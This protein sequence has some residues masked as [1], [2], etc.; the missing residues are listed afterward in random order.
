MTLNTTTYNYVAYNVTDMPSA[1]LRRAA[2]VNSVT[3]Y[4]ITTFST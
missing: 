4:P 3:F 2:A 1:P